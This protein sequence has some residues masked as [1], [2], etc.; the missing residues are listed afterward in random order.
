MRRLKI[1]LTLVKKKGAGACHHGHKVGDTF[2]FDTERGRLCPMALHVAFP[3]VD[4][5][6]YGGTLPA[7]ADGTFAFSCPDADVLN[8]F[9]IDVEERGERA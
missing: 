2:D 1:A 5:L 3:Y 4:I 6:R 9:R 8:I 7:R